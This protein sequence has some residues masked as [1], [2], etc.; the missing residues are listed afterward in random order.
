M[1]VVYGPENGYDFPF[2]RLSRVKVL[3]TISSFVWEMSTS[4]VLSG[5]FKKLYKCLVLQVGGKELTKWAV[6]KMF[7]AN[8]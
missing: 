6:L 1:W 7:V 4:A 8:K 2:P 5:S 3:K